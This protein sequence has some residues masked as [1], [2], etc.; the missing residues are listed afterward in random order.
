M[1]YILLPNYPEIEY[2]KNILESKCRG[3]YLKIGDTY[4]LGDICSPIY[5]ELWQNIYLVVYMLF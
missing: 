5:H 3:N 1:Y 4:I 2:V